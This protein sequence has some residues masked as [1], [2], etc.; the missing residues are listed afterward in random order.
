MCHPLY[1]IHHNFYYDNSS[2]IHVKST[3]RS[4]PSSSQSDSKEGEECEYYTHT[5]V[6][7]YTLDH[8]SPLSHYLH[9]HYLHRHTYTL[10]HKSPLGPLIPPHVHSGCSGFD[11]ETHF[12]HF[13]VGTSTCSPDAAIGITKPQLS[14]V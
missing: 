12:L 14:V 2:Q 10:D 8:K 6:H 4:S 5:H 9:R 11:G 1:T 3:T 7:T 13:V